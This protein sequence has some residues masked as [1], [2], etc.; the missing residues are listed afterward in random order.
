MIHGLLSHIF[1]A[2][3]LPESRLEGAVSMTAKS[4]ARRAAS[5]PHKVRTT[6]NATSIQTTVRPRSPHADLRPMLPPCARFRR[7]WRIRKPAAELAE[8][9]ST[10]P[11]MGEFGRGCR[12]GFYG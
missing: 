1:A 4:A 8:Q 5:A 2:R 10:F 9:R 7:E 12:N 11:Q 6:C 3:L